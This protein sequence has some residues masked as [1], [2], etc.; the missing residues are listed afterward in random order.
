MDKQKGFIFVHQLKTH[1]VYWGKY[2][3]Y[4]IKFGIWEVKKLVIR[5]PRLA[6]L[7]G[8]LLLVGV[9]GKIYW[10]TIIEYINRPKPIPLTAAPATS[11]FQYT[12]TDKQHAFSAYIGETKTN[13]PKV[14]VTFGTST[15]VNFMLTD[16]NAN[17]S[18]PKQSGN[19]VS[20][21]DVRTN[22]DLSYETLTNGVKEDI[23]IKKP[24]PGNAFSF[25]VNTV[26]A[27]PKQIAPDTF[28]TVFYDNTGAYVFHFAKPYA[29]DAKGA[30]TDN[31]ILRMNK[32]KNSTT[33][34]A[35]VVVNEKWLSDPKRVY[36]ITI[37]PT[38]T[39]STSSQFA[40]G[41][42]NRAFDT[43]SGSSPN[44]TTYYQELA[45]DQFT[46]GLYHFDNGA[47]TTDSS[48]NA[49]TLTA[50]GG[51]TCSSGGIVDYKASGFTTGPISYSHA[52]L[53]NLALT[54][55][56]I[57]A[58]INPANL[59][60]T[61]TIFYA[62]STSDTLL[63][64][65]SSGQINFST[66]GSTN[67]A[68]AN[69]LVSAS[70]WTHV[71]ATW[72]SAGHSI[73]INGVL[74]ATDT[75]TTTHTSQSY[76][77]YIG[78]GAGGNT[79]AFSGSID[80]LRV[81]SI[82][83]SAEEVRMSAQ[84]RPY[85]VFT[86]DVID[87]AG[88]T[89]SWNSL[90]WSQLGVSTG[91]G[92]TA[93]NSANLVAQWNFN[94]TSGTTATADAGS[95]GTNCNGTLTNFA[96]TASQ[97]QAAGTGWTANNKRWGAGALMFDG[98]N[99]Y[100][101]CTDAAC[102]GTTQLDYPGSGSWSLG[103]WV[104]TTSSAAQTILG[105]SNNT[106]T[107]DN[108]NS[109]LLFM[110][111]GSA[112]IYATNTAG[113]WD[114]SRSTI[115]KVND[116]NWHYIV[117]VYT[118][119]TNLD[120][121]VDGV[122]SN[123]TLTGSI[124]STIRNSGSAFLIGSRLQ[125]TSTTPTILQPFNGVIDVATVYSRALTAS[126]I[127]SNYNASNMEFQ[128]RVGNTTD[129]NDG[130]WEAWLPTTTETQIENFDTDGEQWKIDNN[131]SSA[132]TINKISSINTGSGADGACVIDNGTKT[133][134]TTVGS[135]VCNGSARSTA[136]AVNFSV[137][138]LA[139]AGDT[140]VTVSSTPTGLTTGDE[141][142][143]IN[144]QGTSTNYDSV[145]KYETHTV[146]SVSTNTLNFTD[147]PLAYTYDGTTQKIMV[148]RVPNFGNVTVCGG[149]TGGG[150]TAAAT[151]NATAWNGTKNGV[152]FFRSNGTITVNGTVSVN[153]LGYAS[154][155]TYSGAVGA[156]GGGGG[157]GGGA[158][159]GLANPS[160]GGAGGASGGA[161]GVVGSSASGGTG[162]NGGAGGGGALA[163][164]LGSGGTTP[165]STCGGG[166]GG[167]GGGGANLG[168]GGLGGAAG[169][170]G[171]CSPVGY[172]GGTGGTNTGTN[173]AGGSGSGGGDG[174][175]GYGSYG[176]GGFGGVVCAA[177]AN[178]GAGK[179]G[180]GGSGGSTCYSGNGGGGGGGGLPYGLPD[181]SKLFFGSP[182]GNAVNLPG[183]IIGII[184]NSITVDNST[185]VISANGGNYSTLSG[186]SAGGSVLIQGN[187]LTLNTAR[188][189][190]NGGTG[191][192]ASTNGGAGGAGRIAL[193][194]TTSLS[195]TTSPVAY[196]QFLQSQIKQEGTSA[197]QIQTGRLEVDPSTVA[198]WHLDETSGTSAYIKDSSANA[199]NGTPTGTSV[200]QGVSGKGRSFN[201]TSDFIDFGN[202]SSFN[203]TTGIT[204]EAW[205]KKSSSG[206]TYQGLV[207]KGRDANLGWSLNIDETAG[208]A[209]FK[210]RI[211]ASNSSVVAGT[212]YPL[213]QWVH[214][215]GVFNGT[216]LLI[217]QNGV[218]SNTTSI[219]G[220]LS[221]NAISVRIGN[222]N[223][224]LYFPG[225]VDEVRIS[226]NARSAEEIA[227]DYRMGRDHYLNRSIASTDLSAKMFLPFYIAA[228]RPG[229]YLSA[230][231]GNSAFANYQPDGNTVGLWHL[232]E[233][234]GSGA[235]L[236]DVS[237]N[238]N[239]ATPTGTSVI[240]GKIGKAQ[241]FTAN[242]NSIDVAD[243]TT[244]RSLTGNFTIDAWLK[245]SGNATGTD[246]TVVDIGNYTA[247]TGFG[248]WVGTTN[249]LDWRINQTYNNYKT[250]TLPAGQ[251]SHAAVVYN[252]SN[253]S[254][255]L[256]GALI[257]ADTF[258]TNPTQATTGIRI[259]RREAASTQAFNGIV[260]EIRVS[261]TARTAAQIR[262]AYEAGL[263][264]HQVTIDFAASL[265]SG[266]L[267]ANSSDLS[268]TID[269]TQYGLNSKGSNLYPGDKIIV[270]ENYNGTDY[271]AQGTVATVTASTGAVTVESWDAS[272]TFPSGGFTANAN[273][274]K[275]QREYWNLKN[276]PTQP[277]ADVNAVTTLS[278]RLTSGNE[279]RTIWLDDLRSS[280]DYLVTPG[281]STIT[282]ATGNRYFQYRILD[283]TRDYNV[284]SSITS[285][286][287]NYTTNFPPTPVIAAATGAS[288]TSIQWN[289]T[290]GD[291]TGAGTTTGYKVYDTNNTLM[292]T[293]AG[294]GITSC[295]E[296][297]LSP[298]VQ[299]TRKV[300]SYN[301]YGNSAYSATTNMYTLA[302][303]PTAPTT[304]S[305]T[306]TSLAVTPTIGTNPSGTQLAL[307]MQT[308]TSCTG[309]GG[310]Y[311]AA[312]GSTNGSTA[313]WQTVAQWS[314]V[315][316]TGLNL[317]VNNYAFC[318]KARNGNNVE[319]TFS[320][321]ESSNGG[322]IPLSGN[323]TVTEN[324]TV[325]NKY[326]DGSNAAR[327]VG[328]LDHGTG[329][330]NDSVMT[331]KSGVLTVGTT[332]TLVAG[333]FVF[334]GGSIAM[335]I[336]TTSGQLK[337]G[338]PIWVKY[339]DADGDG[340]TTS[341][342]DVTKLYYGTNVPT[343]STR[344]GLLTSMSTLGTDCDDTNAAIRSTN[345]TG[346]T[347]TSSGG[348]KIHS[349][350]ATGTSTLTVSCPNS[351]SVDYLVIAGGG[352]GDQTGHAGGGGA[353]GYL[354]GSDTLSNAS[355]SIVVGAGGIGRG[356]PPPTN[357]DPSSF[358][359]HAATGGGNGAG[360]NGG[361]GGGADDIN[362]T[363]GSGTAGQG[364]NGGLRNAT[365]AGGG[366]G[367]SQ[368]G[369]SA[370]T[371]FGGKGGDGI[372]SSITGSPV[373]YCGGGGGTG[374]AGSGA[375][376]AGGGGAANYGST[377]SPGSPNTG[378]G[379]GGGANTTPGNGGTGV[380]IIRYLDP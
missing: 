118:P 42:L 174:G 343:P 159:G 353:G 259:G 7:C 122:L 204:V 232:D 158:Y 369:A 39:Y 301:S 178:G 116:G 125:N 242:T 221:T 311:I 300:V 227:E 23:I 240:Q 148:Q 262:Q 270:H 215:A 9:L 256:N 13:T 315:T 348:Y 142:I 195:G 190:A 323:F 144:L 231:L 352:G 296:T 146:S 182:G 163:G 48:G 378:G 36:P 112:L 194:Y 285:A 62:D 380:V 123:G 3:I 54:S 96:S 85:S 128:T 64:L 70:T 65:G 68:T 4:L 35:T 261:N 276:S 94:S 12:A 147:S 179:G 374:D 263:R 82:A 20:F 155:N 79:N 156:F 192:S 187:S 168:I 336:G 303:V 110:N 372:S 114:A 293:C 226:S 113:S 220:A 84:R 115:Q 127:L 358:N 199:N 281:G 216:Q 89:T 349:F 193:Y 291:A 247:N 131:Q 22:V 91:D 260:D 377:G 219:T 198:L 277:A 245:P 161:N 210:A 41:T 223:D 170:S 284:S 258:S 370:S 117:G 357:G 224:N 243:S 306:T 99:D 88:A 225:Q 186:G 143:I 314:A 326:A 30:R 129:P 121:Y 269:A 38:I 51:M 318:T 239:N 346:G 124:P 287:L 98:T 365:A 367:G 107:A 75:N 234:S 49:K 249:T 29:V 26:G 188:V 86:S 57:E 379:G 154:N 133:L 136:Y 266:N 279:G 274:F 251:W 294:S 166:G 368:V 87:L 160:A 288:T 268:F 297:G 44:L 111:G 50:N 53:M 347:I 334:S 33:F 1:I 164:A 264:S 83:R 337:P 185:G 214:V 217:Y 286:S 165:G 222:T 145:G 355:Y 152:L 183:G 27:L 298:N 108:D 100:T 11:G 241:I 2:F 151:V 282:S 31:V 292:V 196:T 213:N 280:G 299:Y 257:S 106:V 153:S 364:N 312:N 255:Y 47:C 271:Y 207:D 252:G 74:V 278:L 238:G 52:T 28:G 34:L 138:A 320:S 149:A 209:T 305:A 322:Y 77:T 212:T 363:Q 201:G 317:N 254:L 319:T 202:G 273:A 203:V 338:V 246:N 359:G 233:Q 119:S 206:S 80:E 351:L 169:G 345:V 218:L 191:G 5:F 81:S 376:G 37:D 171:A 101:I 40:A 333:S 16:M 19:K 109:Y 45:T 72:T 230:T 362:H 66:S 90:S 93:S 103:A 15:T 354:T 92:E 366:G 341:T 25:D 356:F 328:G 69:G 237:G 134:D 283:M 228:D 295:T 46:L 71:A 316:I 371:N 267:I 59:T 248:L 375:G 189:T 313:V 265:D 329:T 175:G 60:G 58:W 184:G 340:W 97:D 56:T 67:L 126:E 18:K 339:A 132:S 342:T 177:G 275:W 73:F 14:K 289:F 17:I 130:S 310:N 324:M 10:P 105:K 208:K 120:I 141:F 8:L 307:Y 95:C 330:T 172:A 350:T 229:T 180:T 290:A 150:C 76:T 55:G 272:S 332:D 331:L 78:V 211:G 344:R 61:Q 6:A 302:A 21:T 373:T 304:A 135:S 139:K 32:A 167:G 321:T 157:G 137:T 43:G 181:L 24:T 335:P 244:I 308:G 63:T 309:S 235:Y 200:T 360:G 325:A 197:L 176:I 140:S 253:V 104:K 173:A 102:G 361:S 236:K 250:Q 327:W 162:G 205:F